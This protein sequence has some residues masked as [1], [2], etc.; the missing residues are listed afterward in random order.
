MRVSTAVMLIGCLATTVPALA[1]SIAVT[2]GPNGTTI[3]NGKP[4]RVITGKQGGSTS[5]SITT[6]AGGVSGT[7]TVSPGASGSSVAVGSAS[8]N[9]TS[10]SAAASDC[11]MRRPA[12]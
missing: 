12:K 6:G 9:G 2:S 3:V 11:V 10:T 1:E 8:G 4:C 7:T 5:T